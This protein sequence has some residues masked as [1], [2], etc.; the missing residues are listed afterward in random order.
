[1]TTPDT[2]PML[3]THTCE[4]CGEEY[5]E[6]WVGIIMD[7]CRDCGGDDPFCWYCRGTGIAEVK[8][9]NICEDCWYREEYDDDHV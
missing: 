9:P 3:V 2:Q 6:E 8:E 1:M 7:Q 4:S 5:T